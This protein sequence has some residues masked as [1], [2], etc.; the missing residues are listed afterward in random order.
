VLQCGARNHKALR[1]AYPVEPPTDLLLIQVRV[2][3]HFHVCVAQY[4]TLVTRCIINIYILSGYLTMATIGKTR[5]DDDAQSVR[6]SSSSLYLGEED[7]R[8]LEALKDRD[9]VATKH[10]RHPLGLVSV[11]AFILQQVI[12]K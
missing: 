4:F 8:Y 7:R 2:S 11:I 1:K 3:I 5:P 10:T 12:G 6:T 9:Y